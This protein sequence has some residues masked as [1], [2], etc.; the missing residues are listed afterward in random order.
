MLIVLKWSIS[1]N[2]DFISIFN[3][4]KCLIGLSGA[5]TKT[6]VCYLYPCL[7][8]LYSTPLSYKIDKKSWLAFGI[9]RDI[10]LSL[11]LTHSLT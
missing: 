6:I 9:K 5:I 4:A 3:Y 2:L 7:L 8:Y 1:Y 11:I 10:T